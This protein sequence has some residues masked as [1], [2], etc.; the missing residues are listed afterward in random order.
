MLGLLHGGHVDK[1]NL[2]GTNLVLFLLVPVLIVSFQN[3][4]E[5]FSI[6]IEPVVDSSGTP[7]D[8]SSD[9]QPDSI[10]DVIDD[11]ENLNASAPAGCQ[12][13]TLC[14]HSKMPLWSQND[15]GTVGVL[16]D[17]KVITKVL[18]L[19]NSTVALLQYVKNKGYNITKDPGWCGATSFGMISKSIG[20]ELEDQ[21]MQLPSGYPLLSSNDASEVIFESMNALGMNPVL[22]V[23]SPESIKSAFNKIAQSFQLGSASVDEKIIDVKDFR[24][25]KPHVALAIGSKN[26]GGHIVALNGT[27]GQYY[28]IYDPWGS[29]YSVTAKA[30]N[31]IS[32]TLPPDN[33]VMSYTE[34]FLTYIGSGIQALSGLDSN[35]GFIPTY[36]TTGKLSTIRYDGLLNEK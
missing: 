34:Y 21:G 29:S 10:S 4:G 8:T 14:V 36:G 26:A 12:S 17:G 35:K 33:K 31:T 19:N 11:S 1:F 3:C 22:G 16:V 20:R 6:K 7:K 15:G 2:K 24:T 27:D 18:N 5:G 23:T 13:D 25:N 9:N 32:E 30:G 28:V